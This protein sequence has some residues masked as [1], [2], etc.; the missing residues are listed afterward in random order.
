MIFFAH[1]AHLAHVFDSV[2]ELFERN[3]EGG[4]NPTATAEKKAGEERKEA[5]KAIVSA[6]VARRK[7]LEAGEK[8]RLQNRLLFLPMGERIRALAAINAN[9]P[10]EINR[11]L[12]RAAQEHELDRNRD[13]DGKGN[14]GFGR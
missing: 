5:A 4:E 8:R 3:K 13:R 12:A 1:F 2:R 14:D 6:E 9:D 11:A 7:I 10:A